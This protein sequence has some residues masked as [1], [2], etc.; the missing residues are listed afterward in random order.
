[1]VEHLTF[2]L[3]NEALSGDLLEERQ[4]GRSVAWY[5]RQVCWAIAVGVFSRLRDFALPLMFCAAWASLYPTWNYLSQAVLALAM[6]AGWTVPGWPWSALVPIGYGMVPALTFV[7]F[8]FLVYVLLRPGI[9]QGVTARHLLWGLSASLNVLLISTHLLLW[10][11][12]QSRIDLRSLM[13]ENFYSAFHL[14][15]ISI[16]LAL[17]LFA[18]LCFTAARTPGVMQT[19][20]TR[21]LQPVRRVLRIARILS[22]AVIPFGT[23][24]TVVQLERSMMSLSVD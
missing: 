9:F 8:G 14:S 16:P 19:Q 2:G 5:W 1:M 15:S 18:A 10:H 6:P 22:F 21:R 7:W 11:F 13:R 17:S 23:C 3:N 24:S 4:R 12:R 20:R